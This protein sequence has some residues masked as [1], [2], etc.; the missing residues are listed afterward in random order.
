M[1]ASAS[2]EPETTVP[3]LN[4]ENSME[5]GLMARFYYLQQ[6]PPHAVKRRWHAIGAL[7]ILTLGC[8]LWAKPRSVISRRDPNRP[9]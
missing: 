3:T 2:V 8:S 4:S 7:R 1:E 9:A 5:T 6:M